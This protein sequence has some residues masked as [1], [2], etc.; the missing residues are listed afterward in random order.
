MLKFDAIATKALHL[1]ETTDKHIFLTGKAGTGK[2]TLLTHFLQNSSKNIVVIAPTGVAALNIWWATIHSFFWFPPNVTLAKAKKEAKLNADSEMFKELQTIIIDEISMVRA[3]LLDCIHVFLQTIKK[4]KKSFGGVQ[5]IMIWDLY[6]L[7]PVLRYQDQAVFKKLYDSPY[8]FSSAVV[9]QENFQI[10]IIELEKIYR[11]QDQS[12]ISVLNAIRNKTINDEHLQ[13]LNKQIKSDI[14]IEDGMMYLTGRNDAAQEI[15]DEKLD[16][17]KTKPTIFA[18]KVKGDF[19][20]RDYPTQQALIL[21]PGAQVMF[22]AND[23][24]GQRVNGTLGKVKKIV[25]GKVIVDIYDGETVEVGNHYWKMYSYD[26]D[27]KSKK[28]TT[29][30]VGS[31]I[32]VPLKLARAITIHKSQWKTFDKVIVDVGWGIFAHG[33]TYVALSR[34]RS[35]G[36]I[37]LTSPVKAQHVIVDYRIM[38]FLTK[39]QYAQS[40]KRM[41]IAQKREIITQ[42]I[43]QK[44]DIEMTY[45]K[46]TDIKSIRIITP[47]TVGEMLYGETKFIGMRG[48]CHTQKENMVFSVEKILELK[49]VE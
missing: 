12:F 29:D 20:E 31:F 4:S 16:S 3:D 17:L 44:K 27:K 32:Q 18:G 6:Q 35:L 11:Q 38:D 9:A 15:N 13:L 49:L 10:E 45:L 39:Y 21:K 14:Q 28:L 2:S 42:A 7:P 23:P 33:Q 46:S 34:C 19:W 41:P 1:M 5:M 26:F 43:N 22:V 30:V 37:T 24:N 40:E 8:F 47:A 48:M 36:G 25:K